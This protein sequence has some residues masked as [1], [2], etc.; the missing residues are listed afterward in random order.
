MR[1]LV[2]GS[3]GFVGSNVCLQLRE[4]H[5]DWEVVALDNLYRRGSELNLPRFREAG[6]QFV[7]ADVRSPDDLAAAGPFD[8]MVECSAEPS[9]MAGGG[10][11][12]GAPLL[13]AVPTLRA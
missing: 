9:V 10:G 12:V 11:L 2:T 7:H 1:L 5:P 4:R 13:R 3:A 6:V 8:A